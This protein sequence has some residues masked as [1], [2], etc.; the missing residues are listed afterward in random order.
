MSV[1]VSQSLS[2]FSRGGPWAMLAI[3][4]NSEGQ[5][6]YVR[7]LSVTSVGYFMEAIENRSRGVS[8]PGTILHGENEIFQSNRN[9]FP[10]VT[11]SFTLDG[12]EGIW[13]HYFAIFY[14]YLH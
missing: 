1:D 11:C 5:E 12:T 2:V 9:D 10:N 8:I 4:R 6:K 14:G 13:G 3:S 7:E